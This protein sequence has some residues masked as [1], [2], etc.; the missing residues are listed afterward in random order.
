M[1]VH[2]AYA[3]LPMIRKV[4]PDACI[5]IHYHGTDRRTGK[6]EDLER[7]ERYADCVLVSTPD[8]LHKG[9][10]AQWVRNPIDLDH[11]KHSSKPEEPDT[12]LCV[13][14]LATDTKEAARRELDRLR[15]ELG[16]HYHNRLEDPIPYRDMP[17]M[18]ARYGYYLDVKGLEGALS[19]IAN[20]MIGLQAQAVGRPVFFNGEVVCGKHV[21]H[22]GNKVVERLDEIYGK[23]KKN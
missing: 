14:W 1:H 6:Q 15:P 5:V 16:L 19:M 12:A 9:D 7:Y 2:G 10:H 22:D 13:V 20:S 21:L 3:L 4:A 8:L 18:L 23:I 11:F 17:Q